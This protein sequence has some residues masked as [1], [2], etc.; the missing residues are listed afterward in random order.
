M[1]SNYVS[2]VK[3][4]DIAKIHLTKSCSH[5]LPSTGHN[6]SYTQSIAKLANSHFRD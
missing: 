4:L 1:K 2:Y 5:I 6:L 3:D